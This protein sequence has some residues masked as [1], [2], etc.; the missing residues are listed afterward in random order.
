MSAD[1][2]LEPVKDSTRKVLSMFTSLP[3][4]SEAFEI[5]SWA[6]IEPW[7]RE[8]AETTLAPDTLEPWLRRWSMKQIHGWRSPP[9]AI[10]PTRRYHD[11]GSVFWMRFLRTCNIS[12]SRSSSSC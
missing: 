3:Q 10:Q 12:I 6:E 2:A 4:T 8:L 7:Y 9:R 1:T 11:A 5:L